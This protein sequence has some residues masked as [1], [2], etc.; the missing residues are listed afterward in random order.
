MLILAEL[1]KKKEGKNSQYYTV[2][3]LLINIHTLYNVEF[4]IVTNLQV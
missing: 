1:S 3:I 4:G 2:F